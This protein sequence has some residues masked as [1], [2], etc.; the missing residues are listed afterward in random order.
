MA[1]ETAP[2]RYLALV[3]VLDDGRQVLVRLFIT[4]DGSLVQAGLATRTRPSDRWSPPIT[5]ERTL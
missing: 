2:Y 3:G 4:P 5:L 1:D